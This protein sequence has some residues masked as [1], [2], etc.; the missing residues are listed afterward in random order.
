MN[1]KTLFGTTTI[2]PSPFRSDILNIHSLDD[3]AFLNLIEKL[4]ESELDDFMLISELIGIA[5]DE[6]SV[7]GQCTIG[8]L[9]T[10]IH[11]ALK[12]L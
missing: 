3:E 10:F 9:K 1:R 2:R 7:W 5:F 11:F 12:K 6:N 8:E 4:E